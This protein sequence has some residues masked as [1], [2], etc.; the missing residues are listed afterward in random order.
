LRNQ[1]SSSKLQIPAIKLNR[2][3][4]RFLRLRYRSDNILK[5]LIKPMACSFVTRLLDISLFIF[6]SSLVSGFFLERFLGRTEL[7]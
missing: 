1:K 4:K 6:L 2:K 3:A 5:R 7:A